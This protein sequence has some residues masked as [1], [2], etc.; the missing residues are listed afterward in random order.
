MSYNP[1]PQQ[2]PSGPPPG[3]PQGQPQGPSQG[4]PPQQWQGQPGQPANVPPPPPPQPY[5]YGGQ[6]GYAGQRP[7]LPAQVN[8]ASI[9][10]FVLGGL[11]I[12]GGLFLFLI[13]GLGAIF[14]FLAVVYLAVGGVS[15]WAG[16][17]LRQLKQS[18]RTVALIVSGVI[19][20]V[21]LISL[22]KGFF[23]I[24]DLIMAGVVIYMLMQKPV[25]DAFAARSGPRP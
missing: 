23:G 5:G 12:L 7:G 8:T 22:A 20:V 24:I 11:A 1:P 16:V 25:V 4:Q 18:A 19:V 3:Q 21:S 2:P 10:M 6:P 14:A 17:Q 15:I 9:L 13:S